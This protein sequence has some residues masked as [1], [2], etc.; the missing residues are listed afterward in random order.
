[1]HLSACTP[2]ENLVKIFILVG[3][4]FSELELFSVTHRQ[5]YYNTRTNGIEH[6]VGVTECDPEI[7]FIWKLR[8][9]LSVID[10]THHLIQI[11]FPAKIA[12]VDS[13]FN[14]LLL[15][16]PTTHDR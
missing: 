3:K 16:I 14:K 1:M 15:A 4:Q 5:A 2:Q 11:N 8:P 9:S 10:L 13:G 6:K 7:V 12:R